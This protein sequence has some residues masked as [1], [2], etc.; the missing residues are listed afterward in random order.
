MSICLRILLFVVSVLTFA[1]IARKLKKSQIRLMDAFFW[2]V[3]SAILMLLGVFPTIG[4]F[5]ANILGVI[6]AANFIYL[7]IIFLLILRSFLLD[8]RVSTLEFKLSK[9]VQEIAI[10]ENN[11]A[12]EHKC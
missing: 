5:F 4:V 6:S 3:F 10:R 8:I 9:L 2:I 1:F 11:G 12:D 7:V